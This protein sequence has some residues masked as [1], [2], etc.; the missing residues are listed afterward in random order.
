MDPFCVN[1][2]RP[3][4]LIQTYLFYT[5]GK[6]SWRDSVTHTSTHSQEVKG[7]DQ[8]SHMPASKASGP[9]RPPRRQ[10][11]LKQPQSCKLQEIFYRLKSLEQFYRK[12]VGR[13]NRGAE[14][15]SNQPEVSE[16]PFSLVLI[17]LHLSG[18]LQPVHVPLLLPTPYAIWLRCHGCSSPSPDGLSIPTHLLE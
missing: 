11:F 10:E 3:V 13:R 1:T 5:E 15:S 9:S 7:W 2:Y 8:N 17:A 6:R 14:K 16:K 18:F 4:W 12:R